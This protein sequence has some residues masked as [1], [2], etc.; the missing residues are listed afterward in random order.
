[1]KNA[2]KD[3]FTNFESDGIGNLN[4]YLQMAYLAISSA[5]RPL[6]T[7]DILERAKKMGAFPRHLRGPRP[8][9][10]LNARLAEHIRAA[11][12]SSI[13]FRTAP[14][15]YY[16]ST[17][18]AD[19]S[20]GNRYKVFHGIRRHKSIKRENVLVAPKSA[21]HHLMPSPVSPFDND[22]FVRFFNNHC[23]FTDRWHAERNDEIKQF[24][25]FT[26]FHHSSHVLVHRRGKHSTASDELRGACSV[27]FGGHVNDGDFDL[28]LEGGAALVN[29]SS[30]ELCEELYLEKTYKDVDAVSRRS[31]IVGLIN[32]DDSADA[33]HHVA[34]LVKFRHKDHKLPK[35]GELS[36]NN[37][38][39]LDT[40]RPLNDIS[41]FDLWSRMILEG[42]YARRIV[43]EDTM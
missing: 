8:D 42:I 18:A 20:E 40:S 5:N 33:R 36:I 26:I 4:S 6:H 22:R 39:W 7:R 11:G 13:F 41:D 27:G 9:R 37:L 17:K 34:V 24:V 25:T 16:I 10:T 19:D 14:A 2:S 30:R 3:L 23:Y 35:K 32:V 29:N 38:H 28:F 21:L 1:M 31:S 43:L 12:A 15:T